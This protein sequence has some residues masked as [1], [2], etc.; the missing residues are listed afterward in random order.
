MSDLMSVGVGDYVAVVWP[1][2]V[3]RRRVI[4]ARP[5][6]PSRPGVVCVDMGGIVQI[7]FRRKD[8]NAIA[9][10]WLSYGFAKD[11]VPRVVKWSDTVR[12]RVAVDRLA[13]RLRELTASDLLA[14]PPE[15]RTRIA[16]AIGHLA[17]LEGG[18]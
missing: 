6:T 5:P 11:R 7:R 18:A 15:M 16:E 4:R 14:L 10:D 9:R 3:E 1:N 12:E 8:G 2:R 13:A 17:I